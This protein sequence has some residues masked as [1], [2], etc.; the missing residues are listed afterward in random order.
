L[1]KATELGIHQITP[2]LCQRSERRNIRT[3][4]LEKIL[5]S[6]MKQSLQSRLPL[7][8]PLTPFSDVVRQA[9]EPRRCIAWCAD[10][11]PPHLKTHLQVPADTLVLIGPEGDFSPEEVA[12]A[13]QYGFIE[14]S[15]GDT[16]LRTETAGLAA[17]MSFH[18]A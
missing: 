13:A 14:V 16:R 9:T 8:Q 6:A 15:L 7:L 18:L 12:L 3:D 2:L 5:V 17:V 1:E 11:P 4:R 10:Q